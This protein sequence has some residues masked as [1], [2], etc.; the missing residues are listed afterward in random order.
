MGG[1]LAGAFNLWLPVVTKAVE[2]DCLP[3]PGGSYDCLLGPRVPPDKSKFTPGPLKLEEIHTL[4]LSCLAL[5]LCV[6]NP[7]PQLGKLAC[8][9]RGSGCIL[10]D[11]AWRSQWLM[12]KLRKGS[13]IFLWWNL[14]S[15]PSW[16]GCWHPFFGIQD[17]FIPSAPWSFKGNFF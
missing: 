17:F 3:V 1:A 15:T 4:R 8:P 11:W 9:L 12:L 14:R 2:R 5:G 16:R 10:K 13:K 7:F 6:Q